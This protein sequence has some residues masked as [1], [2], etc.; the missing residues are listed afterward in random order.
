[1][2]STVGIP[3]KCVPTI[4][5]LRNQTKSTSRMNMEK[6]NAGLFAG[7]VRQYWKPQN[8]VIAILV[9]MS[10]TI[11]YYGTWFIVSLVTSQKHG[12]ESVWYWNESYKC[13]NSAGHGEYNDKTKLFICLNINSKEIFRSHFDG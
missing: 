5:S 9:L 11:S 7:S 4:F 2:H 1:V 3:A 8:F 12:N 6:W 10:F 13:D